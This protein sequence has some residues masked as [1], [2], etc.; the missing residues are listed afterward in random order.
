MH[1]TKQCV[2]FDNL[3]GVAMLLPADAEQFSEKFMQ[4]SIEL[5][6]Q[7]ILRPKL[8]RTYQHS[9]FVRISDHLLPTSENQ[10]NNSSKFSNFHSF[11][12]SS[13]FFSWMYWI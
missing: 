8:M 5:I 6:F 4:N 13:L 2:E 10:S 3:A 1:N 7:E 9:I 12:L 11:E